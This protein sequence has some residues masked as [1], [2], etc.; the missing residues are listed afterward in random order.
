MFAPLVFLLDSQSLLDSTASSS[1]MVALF[2]DPGRLLAISDFVAIIGVV[3]LS[4]ALAF[5][6]VAL[7]RGDKPLS[8]VTFAIGGVALVCLVAWVPVMLYSQGQ[9]RG[10]ITTV[11]AAA[12]TGGWGI[13][14]ILLLGASLAYLFLTL[15]IEKGVKQRR[16]TSFW[17]PVYGS[18][19]VLGSVAIAGF[20]AGSSSGVGSS[21]ALSL[22]LVLK[23]TLI[24]M[25]GVMAYGDLKDRFPKW[26]RVPLLEPPKA[27][28]VATH[29][30]DIVPPPP[31]PMGL[32]LP[33]PPPEVEAQVP[34]VTVT[35]REPLRASRAPLPPPPPTQ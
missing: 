30:A 19:N 25:L 17:W 33:P 7:V 28:E 21:D 29:E 8:F 4:T 5:V 10:A 13:A 23:V 24:P 20:F 9:A 22:G 34:L 1:S 14:S 2:S 3:I 15:R 26:E 6:L 16:L 12:A 11:D 32:L 35:P 27:T 18:V 31:A